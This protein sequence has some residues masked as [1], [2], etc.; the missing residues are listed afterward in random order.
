MRP[1]PNGKAGVQAGRLTMHHAGGGV[2]IIY[3]NK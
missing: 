2:Y 3:R 1:Y